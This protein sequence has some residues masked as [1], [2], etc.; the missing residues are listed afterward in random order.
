MDD[1]LPF[2]AKRLALQ[3]LILRCGDFAAAIVRV[4]GAK[5]QLLH[6]FVVFGA[7]SIHCVGRKLPVGTKLLYQFN[8]G[9]VCFQSR[10]AF[11]FI[12]LSI[13]CDSEFPN[14][15]RQR[16]TLKDSVIKITEKAKNKM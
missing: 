1:G 16:Q 12:R 10:A 3:T 9:L 15:I 7:Q 13:M 14:Q 11:L 2:N 6:A 5:L 8:C 4:L